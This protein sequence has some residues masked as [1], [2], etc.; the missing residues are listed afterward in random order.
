MTLLISC[1]YLVDTLNQSPTLQLQLRSVKCHCHCHDK[2]V[3][4]L[5]RA[6]ETQLRFYRCYLSM[7]K[8]LGNKSSPSGSYIRHARL[9]SWHR[10]IK[11]SQTLTVSVEPSNSSKWRHVLLQPTKR[12][13]KCACARIFNRSQQQQKVSFHLR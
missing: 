11:K 12:Q 1:C 3:S 8:L 10:S 2:L 5:K 13:A 7:Y 4:V 9:V 6:L